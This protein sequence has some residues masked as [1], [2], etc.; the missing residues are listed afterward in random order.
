MMELKDALNE[1]AIE[2]HKEILRR[3][4]SSTGIN[5]RT[6]K[7]TLSGSKLEASIDV[8][9]VDED[10]LAFEIA[11]YY[12]PVVAGRRAGWK[13]RPPKGKGIV[14]GITQWV[15]EKG[16]KFDGCSE[17]QTVWMVLNALEV[18]DIE[19]RPFIG[20]DPKELSAFAAN[21]DG[22]YEGA[23]VELILPF[24]KEYFEGW[25]DD[26]FKLITEKIDKYF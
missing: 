16:I 15:R 19:P 12:L 23:N 17:T 2:I 26:V 6:G 14:Y 5:P 1:L 21:P 22:D 11:S 20:F 24:L 7:N 8:Y 13:N 9:P 3:L 18:K 25:A 4:L 10:T